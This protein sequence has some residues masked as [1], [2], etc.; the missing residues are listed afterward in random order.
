M[1]TQTT[2]EQNDAL[3][4]TDPLA[5]HPTSQQNEV[6]MTVWLDHETLE[7]FNTR[8]QLSG[9]DP[10]VLMSL[11]LR[12]YVQ[13]QN[14]AEIVKEALRDEFAKREPRLML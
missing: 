7:F 10:Q 9:S 8:A 11:A 12:Q 1:N 13:G 3:D 6:C 14:L 4:F 2:S 5:P